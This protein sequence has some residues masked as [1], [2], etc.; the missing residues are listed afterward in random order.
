TRPTARNCGASAPVRASTRRLPAI[1]WAASNTS[2]LARVA[3]PRSAS[4]AATT[5]SPSRS[6]E[7]SGCHVVITRAGPV[8]APLLFKSLRNESMGGRLGWLISC[9]V[10]L[11]ALLSAGARQALAQS[12]AE[13]VE[14]CAGCHGQDGKPIDK[15]IPVIWGQQT[16]YIYIQ[17]RDY[18][19]GDRKN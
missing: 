19:R 13:K 16:G 17:L 18:K 12:I 3:T 2:L 4:S 15:T 1:W 7:R 8:A 5:S 11:G 14:V 6:S 9:G 10:I